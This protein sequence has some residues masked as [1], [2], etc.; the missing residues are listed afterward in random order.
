MVESVTYVEIDVPSFAP[1]S[2]ED[3]QT[4]RFVL[5]SS[6]LNQDI[7]AIPIIRNVDF[8][9]QRISLG[10]DLGERAT[11]AITLNDCLHSFNGE[12]Y[13]RG[14][15]W[16]KWRGRYGTKLRG[17]EVRLYR[18][19]SSQTLA[20]MDVQYYIVDTTDGPSGSAPGSASYTIVARD[21]LKLADDDRAQAPVLSN[22]ELLAPINESDLALTLN[23]AGI[24]DLEYAASGWLC[25]GGK[26]VV[27]YTR[28]GDAVTITGRAQF[29]TVAQSHSSG[30]R[31]QQVL[32]F[33]G[34]DPA[35]IIHTLLTEYAGVPVSYINLAEWQAEA[36]EHLNVI[37]AR[38]VTEPVAVGKLVS[39]IIEQA[40][41]ALWWDDRA[42]M[43]R[44]NVLREISTDA[45]TFDQDIIL[46]G[47]FGVKE[48]PTK[49]TSQIWT[50]Y[51]QRDPTDT[52]ANEDNYR[53]ALAEFALQE[54]VEYGSAEITKIQAN[55]IE[56][57]TAATRLNSIYLS[58]FR[59]P[60]RMFAFALPR[61]VSVSPV[62]GYQLEW[63]G[64]Q[65]ELGNEL[66][67]LIQVT[68][69]TIKPDR[70]EVE[71]EEMLASGVITLVN[72]V[73][74]EATNGSLL[75]W[76]VPDTWN[77][78]DN[79]IHCIGAGAGGGRDGGAGGGKG[80][81]AG[82]YSRVDNLALLGSPGITLQ[83]RVGAA[84]TGA[85]LGQSAT[86]GGDTWIGGATL[87]ASTCG[88]E[89]G[90]AGSGGVGG[91]QGGQASNGVGDVKFSG[92]DGGSGAGGDPDGGAGGGGAAAGPNGDGADGVQADGND[93]SG[94]GGA[95]GGSNGDNDGQGGSN[96]F[97]FGGGADGESGQEG[98]GGG[99]GESG[100]AGGPGGTGEQLWTQTVS[101]IISAGP[102]GGGG[103]G[104]HNGNGGRG[105][106]YGGGGG[107]AG[108]NAN[109]GD[110]ADGIIVIIWRPAE[111]A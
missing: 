103:G 42:R 74:L 22:G 97:N 34:N 12:P 44:L 29:G 80:A 102:G 79:S 77:D 26:E 53:S 30:D 25:I 35:D 104:G 36:S 71:A 76:D 58:R 51:G 108:E 91:G 9:P 20:Q 54:Q 5:P 2:P 7:E 57:E 64:N 60:P 88:A 90:Q 68:Q 65:D 33:T 99:G 21:V 17:R 101:P 100:D 28:S 81:G 6:Y 43:L 47:S 111:E 96:R 84:G 56:T 10:K 95:D 14:T 61:T 24:G 18:G 15:F 19:K 46:E 78:S 31:V 82:A 41:L 66:P 110:G 86:D 83:Y 75:E 87:G 106:K 105:G 23:P 63:W 8:T 1:S 32:R 3:L 38:T 16:G 107:G 67:A 48:Q 39:E 94:G 93:G 109:G 11:L 69:V 13:D 49:R 55:W 4:F 40:A 72:V 59:D 98:G 92:G 73:F 62:S 52:A 70:I 89:G 37:Y 45:A 50:F 27:S 85:A